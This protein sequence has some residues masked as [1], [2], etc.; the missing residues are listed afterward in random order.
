[1]IFGFRMP[2]KIIVISVAWVTIMEHSRYC[3]RM[4]ATLRGTFPPN[5][6]ALSQCRDEVYCTADKGNFGVRCNVSNGAD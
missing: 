1:M 6:D 5:R 3:G 2:G 4:W